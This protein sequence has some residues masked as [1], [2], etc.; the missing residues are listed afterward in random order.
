[1]RYQLIVYKELKDV[2]DC[3]SHYMI[4]DNDF[5][6]KMTAQYIMMTRVNL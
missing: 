6:I 3:I 1:M 2:F 4:S 5:I